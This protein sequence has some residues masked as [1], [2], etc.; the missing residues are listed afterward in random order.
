[1]RKIALVVAVLALAAAGF[2]VF[3]FVSYES[4]THGSPGGDSV[5]FTVPAGASLSGLGPDLRRAGVIDS[6]TD[7]KVYLR[8]SGSSVNL[9]P[10]D[11]DLR[12]HMAYGRI[13]STLAKGP[14][15]SF[16]KVTIPEGFTLTQTAARVGRDSHVSSSDFQAAATTATVVPDSPAPNAPTLEGYLY[17]QTYF[18]DRKETA[19]GLVRRMVSEF[20]KDAGGLSWASPPAGVTPYQ[21]LIVASLVQREAKVDGDRAQIAAVIYNRYARGMA[22]GID[23]TVYYALGRTDSG[24]LTQSDLGVSSPYN[25]RAHPGLPPTPIASPQ[26]S[27]IQAALQP[28]QTTDIYYVLGADCKHHVFTSS[29]KEFLQAKAK[30]PTC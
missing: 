22:L 30:Q 2:A 27:S 29:Y 13:V 6:T 17:P 8:I 5:K 24:G 19:E 20:D 7:F 9:Q 25:T 21:A 11:Y 16:E 14:A 15:V 18:V 26:L 10:G 23:A 3:K 12:R 4:A 28:A 1:V